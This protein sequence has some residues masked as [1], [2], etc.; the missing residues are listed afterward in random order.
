MRAAP[1][2]FHACRDRAVRELFYAGLRLSELSRLDLAQ[3]DL[4]AGL[5]Q[6]PAGHGQRRELAL[7]LQAHAA[8][9]EWLRLR[10]AVAVE[11]ALFVGHQGRRLTP[12]ALQQRVRAAGLR[13]LAASPLPAV[14]REAAA[15]AEPPDDAG[16][17]RAQ[18]Y[19]R[20]DF[21][22]LARAYERAHPRAHRRTPHDDESGTD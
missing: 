16:S 4:A 1:D 7:G 2:D 5:L 12:R 15:P 10:Q 9:Q 3:L 13:E 11:P 21:R 20:L 17:E 14:S 8:L 6:L 18:A 22:Y 19:A